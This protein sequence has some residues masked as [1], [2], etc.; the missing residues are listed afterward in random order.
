MAFVIIN[1]DN[2][3]H[4]FQTG[5]CE[6]LDAGM[7]RFD[8]DA[9]PG[10]ESLNGVLPTPADTKYWYWEVDTGVEIL[11]L[12]SQGTI[13]GIVSSQT[14]DANKLEKITLQGGINTIIT[15][16]T[17]DSLEDYSV[18]KTEL[19]AKLDALKAV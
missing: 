18:E 3:I 2:T 14:S 11:T 16:E 8:I 15:L 4:S 1:A 10:F 6:Q 9:M 17:T 12:K 5:E 7:R 13:D 19:Q